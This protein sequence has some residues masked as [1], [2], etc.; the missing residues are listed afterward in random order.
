[1]DTTLMRNDHEEITVGSE[2]KELESESGERSTA[3][4]LCIPSLEI[5]EDFKNQNSCGNTITGRYERRASCPG[6]AG[7]RR[8]SNKSDQFLN[9]PTALSEKNQFPSLTSL[10]SNISRSYRRSSSIIE[11]EK[12]K[13]FLK[14]SQ[15][16]SKLTLS[17]MGCF[18]ICWWPFI[19]ALAIHTLCPNGCD[20]TPKIFHYLGILLILNHFSNVFIYTVKSKDFRTAFKQIF[21]CGNHR[22]RAKSGNPTIA[23]EP[24]TSCDQGNNMS[25]R[26]TQNKPSIPN[27]VTFCT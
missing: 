25:G 19:I 14:R 6:P 15:Q 18:S 3:T 2:S 17:V 1:M 12:I 26:E 9:L 13:K 7:M 22:R 21:K 10:V 4:Q 16:M 23:Y 5:T 8:G 20:I 11:A 24:A 27:S